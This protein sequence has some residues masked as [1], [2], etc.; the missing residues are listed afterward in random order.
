MNISMKSLR[1]T[2]AT[3]TILWMDNYLHRLVT[4]V[5]EGMPDAEK[6]RRAWRKCGEKS[7]ATVVVKAVW[8]REEKK[9]MAA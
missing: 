2:W 7:L 8:G 1:R 9:L 6:V 4:P 5:P 3:G